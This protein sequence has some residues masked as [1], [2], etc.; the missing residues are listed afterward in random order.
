MGGRAHRC[1]LALIILVGVAGACG[2]SAKPGARSGGEDEG[3]SGSMLQI[4]WAQEPKF[5]ECYDEARSRKPELVLRASLIIE[6]APTGLPQ[7]VGVTSGQKLDDK[8]RGCLSGVAEALVF[9]A[10][11]SAFTIRPAV[12]FKP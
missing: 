7:R 10:T 12:V 3:A 6:V 2:S 1:F 4:V 9:P 5:R 8:L 11:G